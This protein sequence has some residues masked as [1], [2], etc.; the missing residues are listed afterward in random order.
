MAFTPEQVEEFIATLQ[1]DAALRDRVRNAILADDFLALPGLVRENG[2]QIARLTERMG[3]LTERMDVLTERVDQLT[4][5]VDQLTQ[6]VDQL[7][8]RVD[9][10]AE[11]MDQLAERMDQLVGKVA[12]LDG[13]MF[14]YNFERKLSS[15]LGPRFRRPKVIDPYDF[16]AI[17]DAFERGTITE[18]ELYDLAATDVLVSARD[19]RGAAAPEIILA[20]EV[21]VTVDINDVRRAFRRAVLLA[22]CGVTAL[23]VVAGER[24]TA[25]A[26]A[27]AERLNAVALIRKRAIEDEAAT[28]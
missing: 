21:S 5:R 15:W 20:V 23:A 4:Q 6:R 7:T 28:A 18:S 3:V 2:E 24:I 27:A 19:G 22:N 10:L 17:D 9:Q 16:E 13:Q 8:Q 1:Q 12:N 25:S 26:K 11:R 14:E